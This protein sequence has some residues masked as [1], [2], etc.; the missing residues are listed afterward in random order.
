MM[1]AVVVVS[2]SSSSSSSGSSSSS[3][4]RDLL[5]AV[6]DKDVRRLTEYLNSSTR[7]QRSYDDVA[8]GLREDDDIADDGVSAAFEKAVCEGFSSGVEA[9][10]ASKSAVA[11]IQSKSVLV[12]LEYSL[13]Q[14]Q[15]AI[16]RVLLSAALDANSSLRDVSS[17]SSFRS[18]VNISPQFDVN[19]SQ[20]Y[21]VDSTPP[22]DN[23]STPSSDVS[24]SPPQNDVKRSTPLCHVDSQLRDVI[25]TLD[26]YRHAMQQ[27]F[28]DVA[29]RAVAA[30]DGGFDVNADD[31]WNR[32]RP[33]AVAVHGDQRRL[34]ELLV[35]RGA[36]VD[37][38]AAGDGT[39]V[40]AVTLACVVGSVDCCRIL[41][42]H[43]ACAAGGGGGSFGPHPTSAISPL[44]ALYCYSRD[45]ARADAIVDLLLAAG[46]DV[47][48]TERWLQTFAATPPVGI[49]AATHRYLVELGR[50]PLS[51]RATCFLRLRSRLGTV[52]R[53]A[54]VR[55]SIDV[56][57]IPSALKRYLR[58]DN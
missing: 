32:H 30:D 26:V 37:A 34:V 48:R 35:A 8:A 56:L 11:R 6:G 15:T 13:K 1:S 23:G 53:G 3:S 22:F 44:Q 49:A 21:D 39:G 20:Q 29:E 45:A 25:S 16:V 18:D 17:S 51:L 2:S 38:S 24:S 42:Q 50:R 31:N 7:R 14:G 57:P 55:D 46:L 36:V 33:L 58:V 28:Y 41:L 54:S 47:A 19:S 5:I 9:L 40:T 12:A 27:R 10:L 52:Q 43:G 4:G